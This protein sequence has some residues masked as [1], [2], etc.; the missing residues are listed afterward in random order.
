MISFQKNIFINGVNYCL[1]F[2]KVVVPHGDKYFVS[3]LA[4]GAPNVNFEIKKDMQRWRI[5]Q[6][7]PPWVFDKFSKIISETDFPE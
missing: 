1:L 4:G 7:A 5:L 6:P 3:V 2:Y